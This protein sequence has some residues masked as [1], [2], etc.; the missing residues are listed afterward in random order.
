[1]LNEQFFP[2][3]DR[4]PFGDLK[5]L[6][7]ICDEFGHNHK[8]ISD[9]KPVKIMGMVIGEFRKPRA[10]EWYLSGGIPEVYRAN[11]NLSWKYHILKLVAVREIKTFEVVSE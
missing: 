6:D 8:L 5:K 3:S 4:I 9:G 2:I 1:M 11:E 10:G 7:V